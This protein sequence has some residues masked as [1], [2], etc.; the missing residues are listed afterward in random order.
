MNATPPTTV[1]VDS[2]LPPVAPVHTGWHVAA[3]QPAAL[4]TY[5]LPSNAPTK[6]NPFA[7]AGEDW[8]IDLLPA[9]PCHRGLHTGCPHPAAENAFSFPA[10]DVSDV[11]EPTYTMPLDTVG[12]SMICARF[13][14]VHNG[15]VHSDWPH[16]SA[17]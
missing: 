9:R 11:C 10:A 6:T 5:S 16:P 13:V 17:G 8:R 14:E 7:T 4:K 15:V 1:G 12:E 3:P 2:T